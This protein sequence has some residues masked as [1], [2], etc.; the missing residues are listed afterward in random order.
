LSQLLPNLL[1][2]LVRNLTAGNLG[3]FSFGVIYELIKL[4][5]VSRLLEKLVY[6]LIR[7]IRPG[8]SSSLCFALVF[9]NAP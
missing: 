4:C 5:L 3:V 6:F 2:L 9:V 1:Q 7:N 8:S